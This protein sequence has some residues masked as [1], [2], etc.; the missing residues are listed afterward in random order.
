MPDR[1]DLIIHDVV[2]A[3]MVRGHFNLIPHGA[4]I[5][6]RG[7]IEWVGI[8]EGLPA[9]RARHEIAGRGRLLTPGLIDCHTH[10]VYGG[11]RTDEFTA[12]LAGESYAEIERR[13][14]GIM[15]TVRATR[16]ATVEALAAA[17]RPRLRNLLSEGVTT[18]EIKTGYGLNAE[19]ELKMLDVIDTLSASTPQTLIKT[20]LAH[21]I[22]PE[23]RALPNVY[24]TEICE[25]ILPQVVGRADGFDVFCET[26]AFTPEQARRMLLTARAHGLPLHIHAE[27]HTSLGA[28]AM[29]AGLGALSASHLEYLDEADVPRL[30]A[31]GTTAV[32][33]PVAAYVLREP[34]RPPVEALRLQSI[35][36]AV[37]TDG[38]PGTAPCFS[39]LTALNM[40]CV[41]FGLTP[42]EALAGAT[43][44]AARALGLLDRIGTIEAGKDADLVLWDAE[45]PVELVY[46][47]GYHPSAT[48]IKR[49]RVLSGA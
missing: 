47:L 44:H 25:E 40:A 36:M 42:E 45:S 37:A 12:R 8:A 14:G 7:V 11:N 18:V 29:A 34:H 33:L 13:G 26:F 46:T 38:N 20:Y 15:A 6:D 23:Y 21:T 4:L 22:P 48:V 1:V 19:H 9:V 30:A 39:L 2:I 17:A 31:G 3:T 24:V 35:P 16:S 28:A 41:L 27:Q 49:G 5:A 10:L 43:V 32:L